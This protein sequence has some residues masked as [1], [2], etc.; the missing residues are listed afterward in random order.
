MGIQIRAPYRV[1]EDPGRERSGLRRGAERHGIDALVLGD[2][3]ERVDDAGVIRR[4]DR[5]LDRFADGVGD[6]RGANIQVAHEPSHGEAVDEWQH[7]VGE[8]REHEQQ[9]HDEPE[10]KSQARSCY[11]GGCE[12]HLDRHGFACSTRPLARRAIRCGF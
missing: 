10:G 6:E 3:G 2:P 8:R 9:R 4:T 1:G 7:R 11:C 12:T 5:I